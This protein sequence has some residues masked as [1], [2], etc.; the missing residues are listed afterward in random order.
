MDLTKE[1]KRLLSALCF[2]PETYEEAM[3]LLADEK[4]TYIFDINKTAVFLSENDS[5]ISKYIYLK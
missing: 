3:T 2:R 1:E 5:E 4:I